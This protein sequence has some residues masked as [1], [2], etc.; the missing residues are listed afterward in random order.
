MK[1]KLRSLL[2]SSLLFLGV[3]G[4]QVSPS[5]NSTGATS[6]TP[7]NSIEVRLSPVTVELANGETLT[8]R[9][10]K[11]IDEKAIGFEYNGEEKTFPLEEVKT[12]LF[13]GEEEI[14]ESKDSASIRGYETLTVQPITGFEVENTK[15]ARIEL[16]ALKKKPNSSFNLAATKL[17]VYTGNDDETKLELEVRNSKRHR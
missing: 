7:T 3:S 4:C 9:Y 17:T 11:N 15:T 13:L 8:G 10:L 6:K 5:D 14:P 2:L 12:V 1:T 16:E